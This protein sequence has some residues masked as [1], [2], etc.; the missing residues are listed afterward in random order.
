M[1]NERIRKAIICRLCVLP[2]DSQ[3][4]WPPDY[5]D[6]S[7]TSKRHP[8]IDGLFTVP[9]NRPRAMEKYLAVPVSSRHILRNTKDLIKISCPCWDVA[10]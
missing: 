8:S 4:L 9:G 6:C 5:L 2:K 3:A 7:R 1:E 10:Q